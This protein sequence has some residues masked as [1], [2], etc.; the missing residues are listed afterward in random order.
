MAMSQMPMAMVAMTPI[1]K[2]NWIMV[3][4]IMLWNNR[5]FFMLQDP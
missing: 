4:V 2:M 5:N 3:G 1:Q